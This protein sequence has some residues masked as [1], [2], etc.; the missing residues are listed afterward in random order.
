[1]YGK[2]VNFIRNLLK[3]DNITLQAKASDKEEAI[4]L[5]T[6]ALIKEGS[7]REEYVLDIL[8]KIRELGPYMAIM[9]GV[10]IAHSR[11]GEY[12]LKECISLLTLENPIEFGHEDNDP[13]EVIFVIGAK[14]GNSHL[15]ALQDLARVL[16]DEDALNTIKHTN[17]KQDI[18]ELFV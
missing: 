18:I 16:I 13:I 3:E 12:V 11:P 5:A 8:D 6:C 2:L 4:K 10:V 14:E 7:V 17:N 15:D 1:M 9:P